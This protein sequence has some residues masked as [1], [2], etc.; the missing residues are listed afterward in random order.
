[1]RASTFETVLDGL[2]APVFLVA[3]DLQMLP[4]GR[5]PRGWTTAAARNWPVAGLPSTAPASRRPWPP[6]C[7]AAPRLSG[8]W[9]AAGS[10][11]HCRR[12]SWT[13]AR[14][15]C[16]RCGGAR[17]GRTSPWAQ[18]PRCL[19][20]AATPCRRSARS[21]RPSMDSAAARQRCSSTSPWA[22]PLPRPQ[23]RAGGGRQHG[24]D[25]P[26]DLCQDR[27]PPA[28]GVGA[29][30]QRAAVPAGLILIRTIGVLAPLQP[31]MLMDAEISITPRPY[32][33]KERPGGSAANPAASIGVLAPGYRSPWNSASA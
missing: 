13:R 10:A 11:C 26:A 21:P 27:R 17:R 22:T 5:E 7:V 19:S 23:G 28:G 12:P 8:N 14:S 4:T 1:M 24:T 30:G 15:M 25:P 2:S 20:P 6:P 9:A 18:W 29:A 3:E 16:C 31:V 32:G 33:A